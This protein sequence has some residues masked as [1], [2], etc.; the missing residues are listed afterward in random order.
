MALHALTMLPAPGGSLQPPQP[1]SRNNA[2]VCHA[3]CTHLGVVLGG[4]TALGVGAAAEG[5]AEGAHTHALVDVHAARNGG[6]RQA[7]RDSNTAGVGALG[8][9]TGHG[10]VWRADIMA[11]GR[12]AS[13]C[14]IM[15]DRRLVLQ[16]RCRTAV[17]PAGT[18]AAG[19]ALETWSTNTAVLDAVCLFVSDKRFPA[20]GGTGRNAWESAERRI[21]LS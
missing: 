4:H 3:G 6:C 2:P 20:Q 14:C 16:P 8:A 21:S 7:A 19:V 13:S 12:S 18:A 10:M 5:A 1:S 17:A 9:A 15:E 11:G